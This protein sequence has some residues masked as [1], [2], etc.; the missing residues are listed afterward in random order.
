MKNREELLKQTQEKKL[1]KMPHR[2]P[3]KWNEKRKE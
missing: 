3:K 1:L 2:T